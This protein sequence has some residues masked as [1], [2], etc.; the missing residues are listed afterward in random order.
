MANPMWVVEWQEDGIRHHAIRC[1]WRDAMRWAWQ[2]AGRWGGPV[3]VMSERTYLQE[4]PD[5]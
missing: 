4:H 5:A 1:F 3:R 2:M